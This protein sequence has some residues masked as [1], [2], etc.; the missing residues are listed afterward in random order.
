MTLIIGLALTAFVL[1]FFEIFVPG[2][3]LAAVGGLFLLGASVVT[4]TEYGAIW[5][6]ALFFLGLLA[7]VGLF[8]LEIRFIT[9]TPFGK[10]LSLQDTVSARLNPLADQNLIGEEGVTLTTL[11][12]S[13]K[14]RVNDTTLIA[15]AQ[16]GFIEKGTPIRVVRIETFKLIVERK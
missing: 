10:Q 5:A 2:G 9:H 11:A 8:F 15:A 14:V 4:Y 16:S 3:I 13:G 7:A 6:I 1:F 12:P